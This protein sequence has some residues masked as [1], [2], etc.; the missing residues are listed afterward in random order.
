MARTGVVTPGGDVGVHLG[1]HLLGGA[2]Q[3][4][5]IHDL[6]GD[7]GHGRLAITGL[8]GVPHRL[9]DRAPAQPI[10]E[11]GVDSHVEVGGDEPPPLGPHVVGIRRGAHEQARH[12]VAAR[13][14]LGHDRRHILGSQPVE[15][16]AVALPACEPEHL[17]TE[18]S[19]QDRGNRR[20]GP[21]QPKATDREGVE[22]GI[23]LFAAQ[24]LTQEAD[25]VPGATIRLGEVQVVPSLDDH[26]GRR[27]DAE[28]EASGGGLG[29]GGNALGHQCRAS[30]ERRH[31]GR[32]ESQRRCPRRRQ[33]QGG[34]PIGPVGL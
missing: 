10:V 33:G 17:G 5:R 14:D 2:V 16:R 21:A 19:N 11:G 20:R 9:E 26:I 15:D 25:H 28:H 13:P 6:I 23:H 32:A 30:G 22:R 29:Q 12:D 24:S 8:P 1:P 3:D 18:G 4:Q 31:D 34:E 27:A 7:G